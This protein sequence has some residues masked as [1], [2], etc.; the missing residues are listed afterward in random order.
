MGLYTSITR[1]K[2]RTLDV[3]II[4]RVPRTGSNQQYMYIQLNVCCSSNIE[5]LHGQVPEN[6]S[7]TCLHVRW[8]RVST[9]TKPSFSSCYCVFSSTKGTR[10][11]LHPERIHVLAARSPVY[12]TFTR[13]Y[14]YSWLGYCALKWNWSHLVPHK[15]RQLHL[16]ARQSIFVAHASHSSQVLEKSELFVTEL[17]P[18]TIPVNEHNEQLQACILKDN[19]PINMPGYICSLLDK[20]HSQVCQLKD[21]LRVIFTRIHNIS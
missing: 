3:A 16:R 20:I 7:I 18:L 4:D 6:R 10:P 8:L 5:R 11:W 14:C 21:M 17:Y 12:L 15:E 13:T 1:N 2:D 9:S 19:M